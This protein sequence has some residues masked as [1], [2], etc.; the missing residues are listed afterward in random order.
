MRHSTLANIQA[1]FIKG[2]KLRSRSIDTRTII[3]ARCTVIGGRV[4]SAGGATGPPP[5][6]ATV[7]PAHAVPM[8]EQ[9]DAM[10]ARLSEMFRISPLSPDFVSTHNFPGWRRPRGSGRR[11]RHAC[12]PS[13]TSNPEY[14][15][16]LNSRGRPVGRNKIS[17]SPRH[18]YT[19]SSTTINRR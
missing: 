18:Q 3:D 17:N 6:S 15:S 12:L 2:R 4:V 5:A 8:I 7:P 16:H 14:S 11:R 13:S 10:S 1:P 19:N 9:P